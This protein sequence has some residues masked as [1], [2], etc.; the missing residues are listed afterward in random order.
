LDFRV[1]KIGEHIPGRL[2]NVGLNALKEFV[3]AANHIP[4]YES[5]ESNKVF[6]IYLQDVSDLNP[7]NSVVSMMIGYNPFFDHTQIAY[8][9]A[10]NGG[11]PLGRIAAYIDY[12]YS[13]EHG[14]QIGW[15]G[16]FEAV[17]KREVAFTLFEIA[18]KY[19]KDNG[20]EFITGPA[21]YNANGEVG[22]LI[23][24]FQ[25]K[26]YFMEPYNPPY[27]QDFFDEYGFKKEN[28]WYSYE[29]DRGLVNEYI[30][31]IESI[32]GRL[33]DSGYGNLLNGCTFRNV[34]FKM[35]DSEIDLISKIYNQEWGKGNHP[36][37]VVM[38]DKEFRLL[39]N[40]IKKIAIEEMIFIVENG[41]SPIGVSVS[42]PNVNEVVREYD[43]NNHRGMPS[44]KIF[45][46]KDIKRDLTILARIKRKL[47]NR[48]FKT[49]RVLILGVKEENRKR[50]IDSMLYYRTIKS[51]VGLGFESASFSQVADINRDMVLPLKRFGKLAMTWRVYGLSI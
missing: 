39:A 10:K 32:Y 42:V 3:T 12:N 33:K 11:K 47:K 31:K 34:D 14:R 22:L 20:C 18:I 1:E 49:S 16:I 7:V 29:A 50:G 5:R 36:Q 44:K 28:D 27:Y 41:S 15:I 43:M 21:K 8:F 13:R 17:E 4:W 9:I 37:F 40:G 51:L 6:P 30:V 35:M 46:L 38:T 19:L 2:S 24:G 26:H 48:N 25:F 45:N 23:D